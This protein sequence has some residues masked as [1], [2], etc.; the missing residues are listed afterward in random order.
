MLKQTLWYF[1]PTFLGLTA[2]RLSY[3]CYALPSPNDALQCFFL[4]SPNTFA[5]PLRCLTEFLD[6]LFQGVTSLLP[7][8]LLFVMQRLLLRGG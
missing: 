3:N 2:V 5:T 1:R 7:R 4:L 6:V 8:F